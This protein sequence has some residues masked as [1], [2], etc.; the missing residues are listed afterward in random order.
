M[1]FVYCCHCIVML[2]SFILWDSDVKC[3]FFLKS[4][5]PVSLV[6]NCVIAAHTSPFPTIWVGERKHCR[7]P[8]IR[9]GTNWP[10]SLSPLSASNLVQF[11]LVNICLRVI[12]K[13]GIAVHIVV[14]CSHDCSQKYS[15]GRFCGN[16]GQQLPAEA[17]GTVILR[18][19]WL[20]AACPPD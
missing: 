9:R 15:T 18:Y 2:L 10:F 4:G 20:L 3:G 17:D 8:D 5:Y 11:D 1:S 19:Y 12:E 14:N 16:E 6:P 7:Q 13:H